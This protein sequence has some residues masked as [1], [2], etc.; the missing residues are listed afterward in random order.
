MT[1]V[2][3]IAGGC[4]DLILGWNAG[5]RV[6]IWLDGDGVLEEKYVSL[7]RRD[8]EDSDGVRGS[9]DENFLRLLVRLFRKLFGGGLGVSPE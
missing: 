7:D 9:E 1:S 2:Q 6:A 4:A 3:N 5:G 8:F